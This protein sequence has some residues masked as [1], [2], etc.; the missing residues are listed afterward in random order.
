VSSI[1]RVANWKHQSAWSF[2]P[3]NGE[4][5]SGMFQ[6]GTFEMFFHVSVGHVSRQAFA[7]YENIVQEL[8]ENTHQN[9][10]KKTWLVNSLFRRFSIQSTRVQTCVLLESGL[11]SLVLGVQTPEDER[12]GGRSFC[13]WNSS[14]LDNVTT[15]AVLAPGFTLIIHC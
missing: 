9:I 14:W 7:R 1:N 8:L 13:D 6:L 3:F 10:E 4:R 11:G 5:S 2:N 12:T 15:S